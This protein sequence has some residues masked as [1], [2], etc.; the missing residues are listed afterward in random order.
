[1]P[2]EIKELHIN[3][4]LEE[5]TKSK[6]SSQDGSAGTELI[7]EDELIAKCVEQVMQILKDK[8]QR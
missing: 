5:E 1:M 8:E 4:V 2:L 3:M 6:D 7:D